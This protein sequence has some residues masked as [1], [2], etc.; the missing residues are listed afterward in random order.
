MTSIPAA[1]IAAD[2]AAVASSMSADVSTPRPTVTATLPNGLQVILRED[3]DAPVASFW[4]WYRVGSRN[5]L[6]GLTGLSH[7]VEHMQ[8][9]GTPTLGKGRVFGEVSR[10]GGVLNAFTSHD[11]TAYFETVPADRLA[12]SL[13]IEADRMVNSLFDPAETESERT[14]I[15]NERQGR[16]NSPVWRLVEEVYGTAYRAHPYRHMVL[17]YES[18][19][20]SITRDD[21]YGHYRRFYAPGNAVVVA[22]GDFDAAALL[23]DIQAAFGDIPAGEPVPAV[24]AQEQPVLGERRVTLRLPAPT[25]SLY[26]AYHVPAATHPDTAALMVLDAVLSGAKAMGFGGGG[27]MGRSSRL[28]RALV[29]TG[30]A[31]GAGSDSGLSIDPGLLMFGVTGLPGGDTDA[32]AAALDAEID[33]IREELVPTDEF[34][35]VRKQITAQFVYSAAGVSSQ[36]YWLGL[37]AMLGDHRRADTLIDELQAVTPEDVRRVARDY[38]VADRRTVG[39]LHPSQ[40]AGSG[41]G[42]V[43]V[44]EPVMPFGTRH[45][46]WTDGLSGAQPERAVADLGPSPEVTTTRQRRPFERAELPGGIVL[47]G[48]I[49]PDDPVVVAQIRIAAGS[50][51]D[52]DDLPG[53]ATF[54][55]RLLSRG[56][57]GR[58]F[59]E[60]N[61]L[62]D[63]LGASLGVDAGRQFVD[64]SIRCLLDDFPTLLDLAADVLR[65]PTFPEEEVERV[66]RELMAAIRDSEQST[67]AVADLAMR[68]M[69]YPAGHPYA[70]RSIGDEGSI[71]RIDRDDLVTFHAAHYGSATMTV[72]VVGGAGSIDTVGAMIAE[73]FGGWG[74]SVVAPPLP[75]APVAPE[76]TRREDITVAGKSQTDLVIVGPT[77]RRDHP[78]YYALDTATV[79]LGQL[80]L[81]GRLGAEVRDRRG[82]AYGVSSS[83]VSG[84]ESGLFVGRAGV[85]P[86][87]ADQAVGAIV[88]E[89]RRLRED[90]VTDEELDDAQSYLTGVLP[91]ALERSAGVAGTLLNIEY[92]GLGL[93]YLDRYPGIIRGLTRDDLLRAA[94]AHIDPDRFVIATAGPPIPAPDETSID[95]AE[96]TDR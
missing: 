80:G 6:P 82:L 44:P 9:K 28:Y 59:A 56:Q 57:D 22:V 60:F 87:D 42:T 67:G 45:A 10:V 27:S 95:I 52:P 49:R 85:S 30:L 33:R 66:R 46:A 47:L 70:R 51:A 81:S 25:D 5:E 62:T 75:A 17:G 76:A 64:L 36:A 4:V 16:E 58:T 74:T 3:H 37:M 35:R 55:A 13:R 11:Y 21:L 63:G 20:R 91:I 31:R 61:E 40:P 71:A 89:V 65:R 94:R 68:R 53:L 88:E 43:S 48:Q 93:D 15:L 50:L 72:S 86:T 77:I 18:D 38:L 19:L 73:R 39:W 23:T 69:L 34:A 1:T 8:F 24:L 79:I 32:M 54:T 84:R 26:L 90:G 12:L 92:H 78:D 14:V 7:W 29:A 41:P 2:S 83:I 96:G